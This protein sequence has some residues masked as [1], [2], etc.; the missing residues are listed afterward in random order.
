MNIFVY[1]AREE[2]MFENILEENG[3]GY[4]RITT[5]YSDLSIAEVYGANSIKDT[6]KRVCKHWIGDYKYFTE[7]VLCLNYKSWEWH[8]RGNEGLMELYSKLYY[9]ARD[10]FYDY[11]GESGKNDEEALHYYFEVTD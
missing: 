7:F 2:R 10:K 11:Y 8:S 6:F 4:K 9:Q 3:M 1:A 5:F